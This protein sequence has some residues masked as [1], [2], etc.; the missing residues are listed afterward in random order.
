[1]R[2]VPASVGRCGYNISITVYSST[3][4]HSD[5]HSTYDIIIINNNNLVSSNSS[6]HSNTYRCV[7]RPICVRD[8]YQV[9]SDRNKCVNFDPRDTFVTMHCNYC[10]VGDSCNTGVKPAVTDLFN[11]QKH[12]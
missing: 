4:P 5:D 7:D 1:M 6:N 3:A 2:G 11:P 10:C 8:W 12:H 9:S